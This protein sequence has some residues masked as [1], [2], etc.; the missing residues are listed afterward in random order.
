MS[1]LKLMGLWALCIAVLPLLMAAF[2]IFALLG[3]DA[4]AFYMAYALDM[5]GAVAIGGPL[6][7]T[8]SSRTGRALLSGRYWA[9]IMAPVIDCLFGKGHCLAHANDKP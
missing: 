1:R 3:K 4:R 2:L 7:S 8:V 5:C 9:K 6:G